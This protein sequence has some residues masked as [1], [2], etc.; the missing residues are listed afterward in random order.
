MR[1]GLKWIYYLPKNFEEQNKLFKVEKNIWWK[2]LVQCNIFDLLSESKFDSWT[3]VESGG[4]S[5]LTGE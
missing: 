4:P 3:I 1:D 5:L 2:A